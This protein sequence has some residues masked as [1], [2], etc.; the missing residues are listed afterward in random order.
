MIILLRRRI[1]LRL[2]VVSEVGLKLVS[3][4]GTERGIRVENAGLTVKHLPGL[5]IVVS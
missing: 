1:V 2:S 5:L 3:V 4:M